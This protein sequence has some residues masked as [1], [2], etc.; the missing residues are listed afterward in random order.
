LPGLLDSWVERILAVPRLWRL[1]FVALCSMALVA[2]IFPAVDYIYLERFFSVE[3]RVLPSLVSAAAM[4]I[5]YG[6]GYGLMVGWRGET[7]APRR[8]ILLYILL[9]LALI[10]IALG[11]IVYGLSLTAGAP[12]TF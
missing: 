8:V 7:P 6:A 4:L 1:A 12:E 2:V 10:G 9:G 11:L 3:T 5:M